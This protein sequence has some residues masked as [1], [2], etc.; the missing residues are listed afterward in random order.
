MYRVLILDNS[1]FAGKLATHLRTRYR[2]DHATTLDT[3]STLQ[4][5]Y[6]LVML[7][8]ALCAPNGFELLGRIRTRN[9]RVPVV[10]ITDCTPEACLAT[11]LK[12][13]IFALLPPP[14]SEC[15]R[16]IDIQLEA[17]LRRRP[18]RF[19]QC[20]L[21]GAEIAKTLYVRSSTHGREVRVRVERLLRRRCGAAR[22]IKLL[23]DEL[24]TNAIYHGPRLADGAPVY[25][26][27]IEAH[28]TEE[29]RVTVQ[30]GFDREKYG[31]RV[32]DNAGTLRAHQVLAHIARHCTGE[33]ILDERGRGLFMTRALADRMWVNIIPN[34]RTELILM[35]YFAPEL[36]GHKPLFVN[37]F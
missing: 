8:R 18:P 32:S 22:D 29:H 14:A 27:F 13:E 2:V 16:D 20:L 4:R 31:V 1:V 11:A 12:Q 23:L 34:K 24:I 7:G 3:Q 36:R 5:N 17:L 30:C 10:L 26:P 37:E 21:E 6:D 35:N 15:Y 9:A 33:G 28:L 19:E 25:T